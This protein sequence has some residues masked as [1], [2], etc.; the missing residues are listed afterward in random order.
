M[1]K[2]I[3]LFISI[4]PILSIMC[5]I[6]PPD[7]HNKN[8]D[9]QERV[10]WLDNWIKKPKCL[11]PCWEGIT[12]GSTLVNDVP[13]KLKEVNGFNQL[14]R[15]EDIFLDQNCAEWSMKG[16]E[17]N[18]TFGVA[19]SDKTKRPE[20]QEIDLDFARITSKP[21]TISEIN[22]LYGPPAKIRLN[23]G[24]LCEIQ[25]YYPKFGMFVF[26]DVEH[27]GEINKVAKD[28]GISRILIV[29]PN[30]DIVE[31]MKNIGFS[32]YPKEWKDWTGYGDYKCN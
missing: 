16:S 3:V 29:D 9:K 12:I 32:F 22:I 15:T 26:S 2:R 25:F 24:M 17:S 18:I 21:V 27:R 13:S 5:S 14:L 31:A 30:K 1:N 7:V 10:E 23:W 11:A 8:K 19:C 4:L 20:V 28:L 6:I